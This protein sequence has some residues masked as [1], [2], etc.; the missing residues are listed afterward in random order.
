MK[1]INKKG[2]QQK[3]QSSQQSREMRKKGGMLGVEGIV[4]CIL[5]DSFN[6]FF[7][8]GRTG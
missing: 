2:S 5:F 4:L 6:Y 3:D 1:K 8:G 7:L